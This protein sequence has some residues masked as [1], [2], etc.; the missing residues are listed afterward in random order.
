MWAGFDVLELLSYTDYSTDTRV[1][2]GKRALLNQFPQKVSIQRLVENRGLH[3]SSVPL[4]EYCPCPPVALIFHATL[5]PILPW[6]SSLCPSLR[7][8]WFLPGSEN[9]Q[10]AGG[11][12]WRFP[13]HGISCPREP[14]KA[15][16][17]RCLHG[18][19]AGSPGSG[20]FL[21]R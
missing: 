20:K 21:H 12:G 18:G 13:I 4:G 17:E 7:G 3:F 14:P 19:E 16:P 2:G 15:L 5:H 8:S 11:K 1:S 9:P 6:D 10:L